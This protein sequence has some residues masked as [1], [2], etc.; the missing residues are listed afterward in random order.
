[1]IDYSIVIPVYNEESRAT[2]TL[3]QVLSFMNAF[4]PAFEI[5]LVDD[6]STDKTA[7][8]IEEYAKDHP[9]IKLV[10]NEHRGK[11]YSVRTGVL[12]ANG[13]YIYTIDC[14][15]STPMDEL[16]R[17][18]NWIV[19]NDYDLVIASR[20]GLGAKRED[21]PFYRHLMGRVF[22][23]L[24]QGTTLP[25]INDSQCGFKL[26]KRDVAKRIFSSLIVYGEHSKKLKRAFLG[27]FDVEVLFIAKTLG[28][29]IKEVPVKWVFTK[30]TRL[31]PL[32][33][34]YKMARDVLRIK[35]LGLK[36]AYAVQSEPN[37]L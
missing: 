30:T 27:A 14:D 33:D 8:M 28:Y 24:V 23:F 15:L 17:L 16:K 31:N 21:E 1:M 32:V 37:H 26:Y 13:K 3:T 9:E 20:E 19:D 7:N 10:R 34:S 4:S 22:N 25:G 18:S 5:I 35:I 29:K 6:G 2:K 36:G 12:A 11:G